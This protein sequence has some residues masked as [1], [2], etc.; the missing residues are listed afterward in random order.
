M[1][2][3][4]VGLLLLL[5]RWCSCSVP[6]LAHTTG[7]SPNAAQAAISA[8][9]PGLLRVQH[10]ER[11]PRCFRAAA[12]VGGMMMGS[13][14]A[15]D[16]RPRGPPG[17]PAGLRTQPC[18]TLTPSSVVCIQGM[19]GVLPVLGRRGVVLDCWGL[20]GGLG[21]LAKEEGGGG[22]V[23]P[24]PVGRGCRARRLYNDGDMACIARWRWGHRT[25]RRRP[26]QRQSVRA[27]PC[28]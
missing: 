12:S 13:R 18:A 15:G 22:V 19:V 28:W 21:G 20:I 27:H 25:V 17:G 3:A 14:A 23:G 6:S 4:A 9:R 24:V 8:A 2:S 11:V 7:L 16:A 1:G 26:P 5:C 10:A